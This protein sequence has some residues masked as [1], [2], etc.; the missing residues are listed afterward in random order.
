MIEDAPLA[1]EHCLLARVGIL[2][3]LPQTEVSYVATHSATVHLG[4]KESFAL[5]EDS[6]SILL[7][8]RGRV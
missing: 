6:P 4:K 5:G 7:L 1:E 2:E 3:E 8:L